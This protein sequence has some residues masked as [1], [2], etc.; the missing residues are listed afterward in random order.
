MKIYVR[1]ATFELTP[2]GQKAY[3]ILS[4]LA[5]DVWTVTKSNQGN[6]QMIS[7]GTFTIPE[8]KSI[9]SEIKSQLEQEGIIDSVVDVRY[10]WSNDSEAGK[11]CKVYITMR[12]SYST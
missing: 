4:A 9:V 6:D 5:G 12:R 2:E 1:A 7:K 8:A 3:D 10:Y 11:T